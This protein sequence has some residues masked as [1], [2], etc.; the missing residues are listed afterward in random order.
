VL[1]GAFDYF[2]SQADSLVFMGESLW[3]MF[4]ARR[5][6]AIR[7]ATINAIGAHDGPQE[8]QDDKARRLMARSQR[9]D[10]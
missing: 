4:F 7:I 1:V 2:A 5:D 8:S 9:K 6:E 10:A 3:D